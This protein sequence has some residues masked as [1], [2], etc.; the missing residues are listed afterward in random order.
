MYNDIFNGKAATAF[1]GAILEKTSD[2]MTKYGDQHLPYGVTSKAREQLS[3]MTRDGR[4]AKHLD[5]ARTAGVTGLSSVLSAAIKH[6][7]LAHKELAQINT[8]TRT[9]EDRTQSIQDQI[10]KLQAL[11]QQARDEATST[12]TAETEAL[13]KVTEAEATALKAASETTKEQIKTYESNELAMQV[14]VPVGGP[15][16]NPLASVAGMRRPEELRV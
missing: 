3:D 14:A 15:V 10:T 13:R 5:T 4:L 8:Q 1:K 12:K 11:L 7:Q 2:Q 6:A 9:A 16:Y